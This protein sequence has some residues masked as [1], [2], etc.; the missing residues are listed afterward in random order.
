MAAPDA[1]LTSEEAGEFATRLRVAIEGGAFDVVEEVG[2]ELRATGRSG[3]GERVVR[4]AREFDF[5]ALEKLAS[6]L[7]TAAKEG[8]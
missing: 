2:E 7:E 6:A 8:S 1:P 4:H 5:D 3:W